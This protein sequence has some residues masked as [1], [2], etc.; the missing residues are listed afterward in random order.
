MISHPNR[1]NLEVLNR[2]LENSKYLEIV[3]PPHTL[4]CVYKHKQWVKEEITRKI[5][6][7]FELNEN[8]IIFVGLQ[9]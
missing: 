1:Y 4:A 8:I 3:P 5:G 7:Y 9:A 6:K 2:Y